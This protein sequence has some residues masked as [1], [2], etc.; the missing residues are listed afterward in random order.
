MTLRAVNDKSYLC[1]GTVKAEFRGQ[2]LKKA[3]KQSKDTF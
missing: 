1:R 3:L 2:N